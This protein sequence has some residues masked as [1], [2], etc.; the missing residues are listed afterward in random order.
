[1]GGRWLDIPTDKVHPIEKAV[2]ATCSTGHRTDIT[3]I[4]P[5]DRGIII[6]NRRKRSLG[7][8]RRGRTKP[9]IFSATN[10]DSSFHT[11]DTK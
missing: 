4:L 9:D 2:R 8:T 3:I 7:S 6:L 11:H 5:H 1:V 10:Y